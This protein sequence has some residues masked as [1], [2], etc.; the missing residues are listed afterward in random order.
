MDL[1]QFL[2]GE[3]SMSLTR[4]VSALIT[5]NA[6]TMTPS[7]VTFAMVKDE[8]DLQGA[9]ALPFSASK[10]FHIVGILMK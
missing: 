10:C 1:I 5:V 9:E 4:Q 8:M 7:L 6:S 3:L 2:V